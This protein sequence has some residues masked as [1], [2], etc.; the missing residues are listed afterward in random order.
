MCLGHAYVGTVGR[1]QQLQVAT[2]K[3]KFL[4]LLSCP[5]SSLAAYT[6]FS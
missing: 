4:Y 3:C 6:Y 1:D 2:K 5:L